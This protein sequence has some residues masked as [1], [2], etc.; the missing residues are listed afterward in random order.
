MS[1]AHLKLLELL[2]GAGV[3]D[4]GGVGV[5]GR[6]LGCLQPV[7]KARVVVQELTPE[8]PGLLNPEEDARSQTTGADWKLHNRGLQIDDSLL[9][10]HEYWNWSCSPHPSLHRHGADVPP[11]A[12]QAAGGLLDGV[13]LRVAAAGVGIVEQDVTQRQHRGHALAV[14]LDVPLQILQVKHITSF[15]YLQPKAEL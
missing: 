5:G 6:E 7:F 2:L 15:V 1:S 9:K 11:A 8:T 3:E 14:L 13:A 12:V 10:Q 4:V